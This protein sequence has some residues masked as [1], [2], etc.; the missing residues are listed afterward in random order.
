MS[1]SSFRLAAWLGGV[2]DVYPSQGLTA[3]GFSRLAQLS[4]VGARSRRDQGRRRSRAWRVGVV[5]RLRRQ[6]P[7]A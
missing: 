1:Q 4:K 3:V 7:D 5:V 6:P 2:G